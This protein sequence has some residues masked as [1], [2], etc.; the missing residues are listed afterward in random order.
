V[1]RIAPFIVALLLV[2]MS[3]VA[4]AHQLRGPRCH[5]R[6]HHHHLTCTR[7]SRHS[8]TPRRVAATRSTPAA[9]A[10]PP[11]ETAPP[12]SPQSEALEDEQLAFAE[13]PQVIAPQVQREI[14]E[15]EAEEERSEQAEG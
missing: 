7:P 2:A 3:A 14:E 10:S 8:P 6:A 4:Q 13:P 9:R 5:R 1:R 11:V 12:S 15:S